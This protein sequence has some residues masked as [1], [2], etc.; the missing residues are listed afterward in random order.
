MIDGC[1]LSD[2]LGMFFSF[3]FSSDLV[4]LHLDSFT[5]TQKKIL[6]KIL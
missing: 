2:S 3:Q 4:S 5:T 6:V 1:Y